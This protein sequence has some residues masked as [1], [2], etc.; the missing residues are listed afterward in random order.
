MKKILFLTTCITAFLCANP[1]RAQVIAL[2]EGANDPTSEDVTTWSVDGSDVTVGPVTDDLGTGLDAWMINDDSNTGELSYL[3]F[4]SPEETTSLQ[5]EAWTFSVHMRVVNVPDS[6]DSGISVR[7]TDGQERWQASF[8]SEAD[9]D[10][11][12]ALL[13][14]NMS[15]I[16]IGTFDD[17]GPGYHLYEWKRAAGGGPVDFYVD[18]EEVYS[19]WTGFEYTLG[20][21]GWGSGSRAATGNANYNL[22]KL[23][24]VPEPASVV[25]LA[26]GLLCMSC[27]SRRKQ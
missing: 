8:G 19:D 24:I 3:Y 12:V 11:R 1:G 21:C 9:G 14:E 7:I 2:H 16:D 18:G 25:L 4:L 6:L 23:E 15:T 22:V 26:M 5:E 13:D 10:P 20:Y 27:V 17:Y